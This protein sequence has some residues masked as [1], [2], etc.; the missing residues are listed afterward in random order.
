[1]QGFV[2]NWKRAELEGSDVPFT[3]AKLVL[4]RCDASNFWDPECARC[5]EP[6]CGPYAGTKFRLWR[7]AKGAFLERD[8][9]NIMLSFAVVAV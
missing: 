3:A 5:F 2:T 9:E 7:G 1:M 4:M 8:A 6:T